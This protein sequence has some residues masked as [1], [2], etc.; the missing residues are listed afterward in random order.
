MI[1]AYIAANFA[2]GLGAKFV[3]YI[4]LTVIIFA[5][6]KFIGVYEM[7]GLI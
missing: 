1:G 3:R 2:V 7:L 4:L 6:L 5:S